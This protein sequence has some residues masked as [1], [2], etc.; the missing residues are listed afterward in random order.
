MAGSSTKRRPYQVAETIKRWI[1][2]KQLKPGDRLPGE[3]ELME[4]LGVSKGT[5]RESTGAGGP[6]VGGNTHRPGGGASYVP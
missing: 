4:R 5:V 3:A 2:E 1:V 6:G